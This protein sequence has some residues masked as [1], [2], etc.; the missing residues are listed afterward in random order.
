MKLV[1]IVFFGTPEFAVPTLEALVTAGYEIVAV[2]TQPDKP[3]GRGLKMEAPPVK[4]R[5]EELGLNV[6]QPLTLKVAAGLQ[7][8]HHTKRRLKPATTI[9][10]ELR[11]LSAEV[12]VVVA[13]GKII[14]K[15]ILGIFPKGVLNIH[16]SL[17]PKYRGPSPIQTAILNGDAETGVTVMLLDEEMDHGAIIQQS[18]PLRLRGGWSLP[19]R[20]EGWEGL[21]QPTGGTLAQLLAKEGAKLLVDVLPK[22]LAGEI[23]PQPQDHNGATFTKMLERSDG[24]IDW[25]TP[26]EQIE[27]MV[28]AYDLWPGT[29]TVWN[30]KRVKIFRASLLHATIGCAN[31]ATPGYV[32]K[33]EDGHLAVNCNPGAIVLEEIQLEGKKPMVG[34]D[35]LRGYPK[36]FGSTLM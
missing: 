22:W 32:W 23:E 24:R 10:D 19:S 3:V 26:A 6:L 18:P 36:F 29:F 31:N 28:R 21:R 35:F 8:A 17:L 15:E 12:A 9:V 2:V 5:A 30:E 11:A 1:R 34:A 16:P 25:N 13:Y 27:R 33:T 20:R 4:I 7:P 14:P